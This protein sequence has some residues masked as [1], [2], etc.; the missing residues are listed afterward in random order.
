[1]KHYSLRWTFLI[2]LL[3]AL[4]GVAVFVNVQYLRSAPVRAHLQ[5]GAKWA[6]LGN[7]QG[8]EKEWR[9]ALR[10]D[11]S[12]LETYKALSTLYLHIDNPALAL[13]LLE[14]IRQR[15]PRSEHASCNLAEAYSRLGQYQ[16]ALEI[17]RQAT[18]LEPQCPRAFALLGIALGESGDK[19][20]AVTALKRAF[21][22]APMEDKIAA[23]LAQ[24]QMAIGNFEGAA[25][26][27][28]QVTN[29]NPH[30]ATAWRTLSES[31]IKHNLTPIHLREA[32]TATQK[33]CE[34]DPDWK[35]GHLKLKHLQ[36]MLQQPVNRATQ[37]QAAFTS[38]EKKR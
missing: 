26:I 30:Y 3:L 28:R 2:Y 33:A 23:S 32:I 35:E 1:V 19:A 17:A 34:L 8:A 5:R 9:M 36:Q 7:W 13:P 29:R 12:R 22:L 20:G 6:E 16:K 15:A 31:L 21:A 38:E 14:R 18:Y 24:A 25:Q 37:M 4:A 10:L 11:P 27:A